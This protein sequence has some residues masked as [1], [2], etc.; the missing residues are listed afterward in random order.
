M[1]ALNSE[2]NYDVLVIGG[3]PAGAMASLLLARVGRQVA[4]VEQHRFPR[5]KVCGECLS[6]LGCDVLKHVGLI[7]AV[8][9]AGAVTLR[10]TALYS[11]DGDAATITL[12]A[13]MAGLSRWRFDTLLLDASRA[14]G[15]TILQPAR[16]EGVNVTPAGVEA[17]VRYLGANAAISITANLV[18]VAD[19]RGGVPGRAPPPTG[20]LGIKAH[21]QNVDAPSN[22]I[23]LYGLDG[24][25]VGVAPIEDGRW[26]VAASVPASVIRAARSLD[27]VWA[28]ML[29]QNRALRRHMRRAEQATSWLASPLP[30]FPV[31]GDWPA[32]VIPVGNAA[33]SIEPIGGEGMGLALRSA[34]LAA[35]HVD[36]MLR[37]AT[38]DTTRLV[39]EY[40]LLWG[41]R[42]IACRMGAVGI[43]TLWLAGML[44]TAS[45]VGEPVTSACLR[46][47]GKRSLNH[48]QSL[49]SSEGQRPCVLLRGSASHE[50]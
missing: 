1:S 25:Y 19:G 47:I 43:S 4:L 41:R 16:C 7:D 30:R 13:S 46:A 8:R 33:C 6:A 38:I 5:H 31:R 17:R 21:F 14:A 29:R 37:H 23:G 32:R 48:R 45:D 15:A 49:V 22:R 20:D 36:Q 26:N 28:Q 9:C 40:R 18:I 2:P 12:P 42:G 24:H 50:V 39:H 35:R 34:E 27:A 11:T 10:E 3:G 44:I